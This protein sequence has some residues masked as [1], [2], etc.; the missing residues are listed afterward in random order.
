MLALAIEQ[1]DTD[2][3]VVVRDELRSVA[4]PPG[5]VVGPGDIPRALELVRNGEEIN[6]EGAAGSIDF[7]KNGDVLSS[8]R[9]WQM[10]DG[11]IQD[12]DIFALP[13][14][15]IDLSSIR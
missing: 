9:V 7:D 10:V 13:G 6:Y 3:P 5:E 8:M 15:Q 4:N 2:D 11:M 1:A 12:T 14:D